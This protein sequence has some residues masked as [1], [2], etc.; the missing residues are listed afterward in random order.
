M[1]LINVGWV[2]RS[3]N[4]Q[5]ERLTMGI[6]LFNPSTLANCHKNTKQPKLL[7]RFDLPASFTIFSAASCAATSEAD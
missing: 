2:E 3:D 1:W 5:T 4:Q 6:A 7:H